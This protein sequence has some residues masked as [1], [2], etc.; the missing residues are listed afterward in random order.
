MANKKTTGI[1]VGA[2]I[3][4][5]VVG[6]FFLG[7]KSQN[8]KF[9]QGKKGEKPVTT[10]PT[11]NPTTPNINIPPGLSDFEKRIMLSANKAMPSVVNISTEKKVTV[12]PSYNPFS[13]DPFFRR[14][15]GGQPYQPR[16]QV[17]KAMGSGVVVSAD[18][19]I[20]TNNHVAGDADVIRIGFSD[21]RTFE[22]KVVGTDPGPTSRS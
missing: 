22:A 2:L 8:L 1:L 21:K 6:G 13:Q 18:G 4:A 14:F 20:L 3:L 12:Q 11:P 17:Q 10:E 7:K 9:F 5:A 16:S 15:F 19:Y